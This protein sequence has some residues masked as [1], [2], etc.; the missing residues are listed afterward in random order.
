[1][2]GVFSCVVVSNERLAESIFAITVSCPDIAAVARAGQFINIKCGAE[3]LLRRPISICGIDGD[4]LRV[5]FEARGAGTGWLSGRES[6][7]ELDVFGPLGNGFSF[8]SGN[9]I[10]VGGGIGAPP[11]LFAA[12]SATGG[13]TAVLG[14]RDSSRVILKDEFEA[15]CDR[16]HIATDDGSCGI[17]GTAALPLENLL[18]IGGYDA[19][20]ACGPRLMLSVAADICARRGVPC[21]VSLEERMGCGIGACLVCACATIQD[22]T[23]KM[24]RV[25]KD[26]PVFPSDIVRWK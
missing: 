3:R 12:Q 20:L 18:N 21:Q 24:S 7:E 22:G 8:P 19:V 17:R 9:I 11:L 25:C 6:G 13:A 23:E 10:V 16:V 2:M 1:M 14:F 4:K 5:V 26:G 15:V